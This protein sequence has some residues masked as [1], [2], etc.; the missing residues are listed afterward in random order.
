MAVV[1]V[2]AAVVFLWP[3]GDDGGDG[4]G[5]DTGAAA[6]ANAEQETASLAISGED[7]PT[8][9]ESESGASGAVLSA[10]LVEDAGGG[11]RQVG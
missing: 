5:A 11:W 1:L 9:E 10:I 6:A 8:L 2:I 7:L 4:A 3:S